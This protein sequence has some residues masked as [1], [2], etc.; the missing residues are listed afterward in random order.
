M[1]RSG[2]LEAR[3]LVLDVI[4]ALPLLNV[5]FWC[6]SHKFFLCVDKGNC[7]YRKPNIA[8]GTV[9]TNRKL[10][11]PD[12]C[13]WT[14]W[15]WREIVALFMLYTSMNWLRMCRALTLQISCNFSLYPGYSSVSLFHIPG[16]RT[17]Q[18]C[19]VCIS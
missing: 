18:L 15:G 3:N 14:N 7:R 6:R 1:H 17:W 13:S 5:I 8:C 9:D 16:K 10:W 11:L 2:S 4:T 19:R 12:T